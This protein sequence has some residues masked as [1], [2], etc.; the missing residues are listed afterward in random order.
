MKRLLLLRHA[1]SSWKDSSLD[2]FERPLNRRGERSAPRMAAFLREAGLVP[3]L[4]LVSSARRALNTWDLL[5][6]TLG[7]EP[8]VRALKTLYMAS[9][10]VMLQTLRR[11]PEQAGCVMLIGHNPGMENLA[12]N[13]IG[14]GSKTLRRRMAA[15]FPTTAVAV[16]DFDLDDWAQIEPGKGK[17]SAFVTPADLEA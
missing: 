8:E 15:K 17:L 4:L 3:D 7:A 5:R 16:I 12:D 2:D 14:S 9:P 1:K 10:G 13:L 6:P 11:A